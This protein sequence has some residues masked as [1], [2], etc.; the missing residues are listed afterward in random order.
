[1]SASGRLAK[2][3]FGARRARDTRVKDDLSE[4]TLSLHLPP[5][6]QVPQERK[7][8]REVSTSLQVIRERL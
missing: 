8:D 2:G 5:S 4:S 6:P 1:M 3:G 7:T